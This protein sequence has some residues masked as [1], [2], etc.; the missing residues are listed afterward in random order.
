MEDKVRSAKQ[1]E[2]MNGFKAKRLELSI[3]WRDI[4]VLSRHWPSQTDMPW[5]P[6]CLAD[7]HLHCVGYLPGSGIMIKTPTKGPKQRENP[8]LLGFKLICNPLGLSR[9]PRHS[10]T[11]VIFSWTLFFC[12]RQQDWNLSWLWANLVISEYRLSQ[13]FPLMAQ[14]RKERLFIRLKGQGLLNHQS[15]G[16]RF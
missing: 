4:W 1:Q 13:H 9:C 11:H 15:S 10:L 14:I 2:I 12:H 3:C 16:L 8:L 5:V 6:G 7:E